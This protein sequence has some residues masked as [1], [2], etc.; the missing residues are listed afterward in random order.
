[1]VMKKDNDNDNVMQKDNDAMKKDN[2]NDNVMKKDNDNVMKK[3]NDNDNVMKKDNNKG[4]GP[5]LLSFFIT[6]YLVMLA[7]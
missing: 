4:T 1:M 6:P 2:D 3:D 7:C 5:L